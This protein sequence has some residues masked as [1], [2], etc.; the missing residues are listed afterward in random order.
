VKTQNKII[1]IVCL[2]LFSVKEVFAKDW[3]ISINTKNHM[4]YE[5]KELVSFTKK[6]LSINGAVVDPLLYPK[7]FSYISSL[8]S[9][10]NGKTVCYEGT[11]I[12]KLN[13]KTQSNGCMENTEYKVIKKSFNQLKYLAMLSSN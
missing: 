6:K 4:G 2:C 10:H 11:Y 3:K 5:I 1:F 9:R 8:N 7:A 12:V 13:N